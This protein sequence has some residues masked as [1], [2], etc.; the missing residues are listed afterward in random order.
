MKRKEIKNLAKKVIE[1]QIM[2]EKSTDPDQSKNL[3][4][5][6][7]KIYDQV[8]EENFQDLF[9]LQEEVDNLM[10]KNFI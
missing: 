8:V 3:E 9:K 4:L 7:T 5:A 10:Q 6:I 2:L 1:Y